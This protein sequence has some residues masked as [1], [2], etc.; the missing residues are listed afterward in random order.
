[1][2]KPVINVPETRD[3][4][5]EPLNQDA[6][7]MMQTLSSAENQFMK[8]F[9]L[10]ATLLAVSCVK[11]DT[12]CCSHIGTLKKGSSLGMICTDQLF[13]VQSDGT[14]FQPVATHDLLKNFGEGNVIRFGYKPMYL[15]MASCANTIELLCASGFKNN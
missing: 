9:L 7:V 12:E 5:T 2:A 4:A 3:K 10:I 15:G 13:I 6:T 8:S 1:M 14:I 11:P